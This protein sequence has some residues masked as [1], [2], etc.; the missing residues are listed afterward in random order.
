MRNKD[1]NKQAVT[2]PQIR[3]D[4]L[5]GTSPPPC[6][7]PP[8]EMCSASCCRTQTR[9]KVTSCPWRRFWP[10]ARSWRAGVPLRSTWSE[11]ERPNSK[12]WEKPCTTAQSTDTWTSPSTSAASVSLWVSLVVCGR[13][14]WPWAIERHSSLHLLLDFI[15]LF[16]APS[17]P[18]P[19]LLQ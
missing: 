10:R 9:G 2:S 3:T 14:F 4:R 12:P 18:P 7:F 17:P 16:I 13:A 6:A 8:P 19:T 1:L 11:R 15:I 5:T